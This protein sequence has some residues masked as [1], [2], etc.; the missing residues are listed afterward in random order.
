MRDIVRLGNLK[1]RKKKQLSEVIKL[2]SHNTRSFDLSLTNNSDID[3]FISTKG[4]KSMGYELRDI[5]D[6]HNEYLKKLKKFSDLSIDFNI[7]FGYLSM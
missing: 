3:F 7:T 5:E 2:N 6:L 4:L 1:R